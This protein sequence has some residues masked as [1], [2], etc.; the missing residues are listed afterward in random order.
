MVW[1]GRISRMSAALVL[2]SNSNQAH[3]SWRSTRSPRSPTKVGSREARDSPRVSLRAPK[4]AWRHTA[5]TPPSQRSQALSV[6]I[7]P[8]A[9]TTSDHPKARS[10]LRGQSGSCFSGVVVK[11]P[12][13]ST[14][15]KKVFSVVPSNGLIR[16]GGGGS[17]STAIGDVSGRPSSVAL[18]CHDFPAE[19]LTRTG[20]SAPS[21]LRLL[22]LGTYFSMAPKHRRLRGVKNGQSQRMPPKA[23]KRRKTRASRPAP[24]HVCRCGACG[25]EMR[26]GR[27]RLDD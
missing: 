10:Q 8:F 11:R 23:E 14:P 26:P 12:S 15:T 20:I 6:P 9:S 18:I 7:L 17:G 19:S 3:E 4:P 24:D 25:K 2:T 22:L 21:W 13:V 27:P 1:S 16:Q 5:G